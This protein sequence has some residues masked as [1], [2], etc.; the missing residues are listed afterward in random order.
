MKEDGHTAESIPQ[1]VTYMPF[2][3][4]THRT[5]DQPTQSPER[6]V[7]RSIEVSQRS[8]NSN[9]GLLADVAGQLADSATLVTSP[10]GNVTTNNEDKETARSPSF[11]QHFSIQQSGENPTEEEMEVENPSPPVAPT[12]TP[13]QTETMNTTNAASNVPP[14]SGD[15]GANL[16]NE[17]DDPSLKAFFTPTRL[18]PTIN[19]YGMQAPNGQ[20]CVFPVETT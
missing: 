12:H 18:F 2:I 7:Q 10:P 19:P 11:G 4:F 1:P 6:M 14:R 16:T 8:D 13:A 15:A 17:R 5:D 20:P 9:L 3:P